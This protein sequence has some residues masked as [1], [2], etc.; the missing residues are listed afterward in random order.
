LSF[1]EL[2]QDEGLGIGN[3]CAGKRFLAFISEP[4]R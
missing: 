2:A 4:K 3:E 1:D